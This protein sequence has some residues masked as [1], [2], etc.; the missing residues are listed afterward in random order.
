[1]VIT[2]GICRTIFSRTMKYYITTFLFLFL[3]GFVFLESSLMVLGLPKH[4]SI[5]QNANVELEK[6][7]VAKWWV[8][9]P[10]VRFNKDYLNSHIINNLSY[11][12]H[13]LNEVNTDGFCTKEF[14]KDTSSILLLGDSFLW[15][16]GGTPS[17][18]DVLE[19]KYNIYN[20]GIPATGTND[21]VNI[22]FYNYEKLKSKKVILFFYKNDFYEN[23]LEF[24]RVR[25]NSGIC[26]DTTYKLPLFRISALSLPKEFNVTPEQRSKTLGALFVL[27]MFCKQWKA[28]LEIVILPSKDEV[29]DDI[30][31]DI[32]NELEIK[33]TVLSGLTK[34]DYAED[35][36]HYNTQ[37]HYKIFKQIKL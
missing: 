33:Y 12:F 37:G 24:P 26:I 21:Q 11:N 17:F 13:R 16:A 22:L 25:T 20:L 15:G 29:G 31:I 28:D 30:V 14:K 10:Y 36:V 23:T 1:M 2:M 27:N 9:T 32:L 6:H 3:A 18:G 35:G 5:A 4:Y 7:G 19:K 34:E 8:N